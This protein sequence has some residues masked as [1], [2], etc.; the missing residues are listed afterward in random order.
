MAVRTREQISDQMRRIRKTDTKPEL[1]VR[2]LVHK[3]GFRFRLHRH[4]LP[5]TPDLVF[6]TRRKVIFVHGCF[7]HQHICHLGGRQP[8]SNRAYWLPKLARNVERDNITRRALKRLGWQVMV[9][10]ECETKNAVRLI[11]RAQPAFLLRLAEP[12]SIS[13]S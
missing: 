8:S 9:I 10:W 5:G 11:P 7:W 2:K 1:V 12:R 6:V 4:D 13:L 3:M